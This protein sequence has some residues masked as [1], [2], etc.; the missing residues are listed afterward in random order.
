MKVAFT[1]KLEFD[2][3]EVPKIGELQAIL[4]IALEQGFTE[5]TPVHIRAGE[6]QREHDYFFHATIGAAPVEVREPF[7]PVH[8]DGSLA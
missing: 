5:D 4:R 3:R 2:S 1:H 8:E 6:D 7:V